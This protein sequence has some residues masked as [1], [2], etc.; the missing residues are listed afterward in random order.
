MG[1]SI[2][3]VGIMLVV[4]C[5]TDG[6]ST[7][8]ENS[9]CLYTFKVPAGDCSQTPGEDQLLKSSVI[10]LQAQVKLQ[11]EQLKDVV[12]LVND[13]NEVRAENVK[14][15]EKIATI[16]T[17][18]TEKN[19]FQYEHSLR[20]NDLFVKCTLYTLQIVHVRPSNR[21]NPQL[22]LKLDGRKEE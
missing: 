9:P 21:L 4:L 6:R 13:V 3:H 2:M 17:G 8:S 20:P 15:R 19:T 12:K 11:A 1:K 16:E 14:L 10:A 22:K 18:K 7:M 5:V